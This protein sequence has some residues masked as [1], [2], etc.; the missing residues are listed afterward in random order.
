[1]LSV[2][3]T[4]SHCVSGKVSQVRL[5]K[6]QSFANLDNFEMDR[7]AFIGVVQSEGVALHWI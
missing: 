2:H 3:K 7:G 6:Q 1:M 4:I 5:N